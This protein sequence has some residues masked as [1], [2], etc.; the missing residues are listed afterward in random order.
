ML[1]W[2][3]TLLLSE[4]SLTRSLTEPLELRNSGSVAFRTALPVQFVDC[5]STSR[6][7]SPSTSQTVPPHLP[8]DA[9]L[10]L[11]QYRAPGR[12]DLATMKQSSK[13]EQPR[14][15]N[16]TTR[17]RQSKCRSSLD[18]DEVLLT[19]DRVAL[20]DFCEHYTGSAINIQDVSGL[21]ALAR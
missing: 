19:L 5:A 3:G 17:Y 12:R 20:H 13:D 21:Q 18:C 16:P 10:K 11:M 8:V 2:F 6:G 7:D 4:I 14:Q 1:S 15:T 9:K